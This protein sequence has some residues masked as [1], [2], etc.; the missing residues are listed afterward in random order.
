MELRALL[1][2]TPYSMD[3]FKQSYKTSDDALEQARR[4]VIRA[5]MGFASASSSGQRTGFRGR[6]GFDGGNPPPNHWRRYPA[7]IPEYVERLQGVV[8]DNRNFA[9]LAGV[10]DSPKTLFYCDPPYVL[11]TR[12]G[13]SRQSPSY[14]FEMTDDDH[15]D[16]AEQLHS[17]KGM[18]VPPGVR[19]FGHSTGPVMDR[20]SDRGREQQSWRQKL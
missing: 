14:R 17:L 12:S 20:R 13:K 6:N 8:I 4:T 18:V 2:L 1:E 3:E 7:G 11:S 9:E 16:L 5:F 19:T 15:R 10:Y